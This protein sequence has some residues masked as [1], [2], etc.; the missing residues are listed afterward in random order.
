MDKINIINNKELYKVFLNGP[1]DNSGSWS[2]HPYYHIKTN[3]IKFHKLII[4]YKDRIKIYFLFRDLIIDNDDY[5]SFVLDYLCT[6]CEENKEISNDL[7]MEQ[8][9]KSIKEIMKNNIPTGPYCYNEDGKCP[10]WSIDETKEQHNNGF[11]R[12]INRGD[13]DRYPFSLL[14]DEVKE[15]GIKNDLLNECGEYN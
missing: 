4:S 15:C 7:L 5:N 3:K 14:W 1:Y 2:I 8:N 10:Y 9:G 12:Y 11:Y 6:L 13:W